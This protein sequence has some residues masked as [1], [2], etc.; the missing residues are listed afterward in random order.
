MLVNYDSETE[1]ELLIRELQ[2]NGFSD[3][4]E[5]IRYRPKDDDGDH[6]APLLIDLDNKRIFSASA[7]MA[8]LSRAHGVR[9]YTADE[10]LL[11]MKHG[12]RCSLPKVLFHVPHDGN[13]FPRELM[14]S[15]RISENKFR[16]YH[17]I[18]RD[19][20]VS[21]L[22]PASYS[23]FPYTLRFDVSRLLCDVERF[24]GPEEPMEQ[25]GMGFCYSKAYDGTKIK[26]VWQ[27]LKEDTLVYYRRHHQM[28]DEITDRADQLL[29]IDLHSFSDEIIPK[30]LLRAMPSAAADPG[31]AGK[32]LSDIVATQIPDIC[33]GTDPS[34]TPSFLAKRAQDLFSA[35]GFHSEEN[36]PYQGCMVPNTILNHTSETRFASIMI[37]V[38]KRVYLDPH[39]ALKDAEILMIREILKKLI[40]R[41]HMECLSTPGEQQLE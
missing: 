9:I 26:K 12:F 34:C 13:E 15:L 36:Y 29:L 25:Y 38:N 17:E 27:T 24:T 16:Q 32:A 40:L 4:R 6:Y 2:L 10:F 33:I 30:D 5:C 39:G 7:M 18:M 14:T 8:S 31:K 20:N 11:M 37:E 21:A 22:I 41:Y 1:V 23:H 19:K 35:A 3:K 28:L